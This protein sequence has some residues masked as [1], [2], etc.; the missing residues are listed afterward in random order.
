MSSRSLLKPRPQ[1]TKLSL[2]DPPELQSTRK[3]RNI[4][5]FHSQGAGG[6]RPRRRCPK[7]R[8]PER[9][10][11][12]LAGL[13]TPGL[14]RG[15]GRA[16]RCPG[17]WSRRAK[18]PCLPEQTSKADASPLLGRSPNPQLAHMH[19]GSTLRSTP[20]LRPDRSAE[21]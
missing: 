16:T 21:I 8:T 18:S 4:T 13:W 5:N 20:A 2:L 10:R 7:Q 3:A 11:W 19:L 15:R 17:P 12:P 1:Q 14:A 9:R 6:S